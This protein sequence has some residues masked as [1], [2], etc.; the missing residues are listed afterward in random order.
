MKVEDYISE[1]RL[2]IYTDVLKLRPEETLGGYNWNKALAAAMQPLLHC[3]EITLRNAIDHSIRNTPLP[4]A[5]GKWRTDAF[6]IFDLPRYIGDQAYIRQGKRYKTNSEG[7]R[8]LKP[9]GSPVYNFTVWEEVCIRN[10]SKRIRDAGK[11]LTAERVISGLDF[12]FWTNLLTKTYQEPRE[13]SLLWPLLLNKV[14]PGRPVGTSRF[15]L[16]KK[17]S[18]IRELRNRLAHHEAIWKF[19]EEGPRGQLDY[20]RPVYGM[21]ASL[22]LLRRAWDDMLEALRWMSP[23]RHSAFLA[24][25]HHMRFLSLASEEGLFSFTDHKRISTTLNISNSPEVGVLLDE[26]SKRN[27]VRLVNGQQELAIIAP[28]FI[29]Q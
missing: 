5:Q 27:V 2:K 6:W 9:D 4:G 15:K 20:R 12:G 18:R 11:K 3:L 16:E 23:E 21:K 29:R 24:E 28:D 13:H 1:D 10:A 19:H 25:G 8:L 26:L 7:N 22:Q 17:F 14:F